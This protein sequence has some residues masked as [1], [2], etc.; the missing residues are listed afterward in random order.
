MRTQSAARSSRP[1]NPAARPLLRLVLATAPTTHIAVP[2]SGGASSLAFFAYPALLSGGYELVPMVGS[3]VCG[4][5]AVAGLVGAA[6]VRRK[7]VAVQS[8]F[9]RRASMNS[10]AEAHAD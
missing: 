2:Q 3:T 1:A 7:E 4:L 5:V 6:A 8:L 9:D 10:M